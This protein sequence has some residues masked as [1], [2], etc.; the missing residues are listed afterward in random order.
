MR[1]TGV[2]YDIAMASFVSTGT[3][4]APVL[5]SNIG[6]HR[7]AN[8]IPPNNQPGQPPVWNKW[9]PKADGS[10]V[11]LQAPASFNKFT[12]KVTMS[13]LASD[14]PNS[15]T[16]ELSEI[17]G[18]PVVMEDADM[19]IQNT[20]WGLTQPT[21]GTKQLLYMVSGPNYGSDPDNVTTNSS[22]GTKQVTLQLWTADKFEEVIGASSQD[23]KKGLLIENMFPTQ[24]L[25][26][27][28]D[29]KW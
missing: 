1:S 29:W 26:W 21:Q 4:T 9:L 20:K 8:A 11:V 7:I 10:V 2:G 14:K 19:R 22:N 6:T 23:M 28:H 5:A 25:S 15:D 3:D 24:T 17:G 13:I 16:L 27:S 12:D 18:W